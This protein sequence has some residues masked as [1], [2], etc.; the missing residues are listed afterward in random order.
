[1][2]G[3]HY[4]QGNQKLRW[5]P[6]AAAVYAAL[7]GGFASADDNNTLQ[8]IIVTAT[9]RA[10]SA[11]DLPI[12]IS[13]V[14]GAALDAAGI[15]DMSGL[16]RSMAGVN[17]TDKGPFTL[18]GA[19]L[20]IRGLNSDPTAYIFGLG[21]LVVP[22]V[23]TYVD[24][25]P[26]FANLKLE[27]LDRVEVLRGPQ[28]TLYGSGSLGGTIR[29]VQN[30]PDPGAF[31]AKLNVG[32]S[33]T[34]HTHAPNDE[35]SGVL[36]IPLAENLALRLNGS[37]SEQAGFI[38]QPLLY[39]QNAAGVPVPAQPGNLLSAPVTYSESGTNLYNYHTARVALLW[40]PIDTLRLQLSY[41]HQESYAGGYP[42]A[43][44]LY[45][46]QALTS[47]DHLRAIS[48]DKV[49]VI[50]LTAEAQL[51]FATLT[52]DSSWGRHSNSS[53]GDLTDWYENF[54]FYSSLYGSNPRAL[55]VDDEGFNDKILAEEIRLASK[56]GGAIDWVAGAFYKDQTTDITEHA[57]YPGY[58][59]YF[60]ACVPIYG[61]SSGN[62]VTPSQCGIGETAYT[63][64]SVNYVNGIP[65]IKDQAYIGDSQTRFTDMALF[66]ETTWHP[67][68]AL[69]ITG[70][71]RILKQTV[72]QAQQVGLLFDGPAYLT[73]DSLGDS[74]RR[75]L[76]K[77]NISY[78][79][80]PTNLVYA[81]WSQGFRR[82]G[83]NALPPTEP[84]GYT[85]NPA[86]LHA[87]PDKADNYEVGVKG[88]VARRLRYSA[89]VY[90]IQW[91]QVQEA[92]VLTP[93][94]LP[95]AV[96]IGNA[97]SRGFES[98]LYALLT[99]KL[100]AQLD[101][102]Y[103]TTK[104]TSINQEI[105]AGLA[106]PAPSVGAPLPGTPKNSVALAVEYT[107][108]KVFGGDLRYA[109]S[110]H[111]QSSLVP[112]LSATIPTVAGFA[113][114]DL[115]LSYLISHLTTTLYVDNVGNQLGIT[116]YTDPASLG[117]NYQA[118]V[119]RPR[120]VGVRIAYSLK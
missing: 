65:I 41:H 42:Y 12:S 109:V 27:D 90:D 21:S 89:A 53:A 102:T 80:D 31:D 34:S 48:N 118:I 84:G 66:G 18:N 24:D 16:A 15:N 26:L 4:T 70:G 119:S 20:I 30:A 83:V 87:Q 104:L 13:A 9:R 8:E 85:T 106:V 86:L 37:Y 114:V 17:F 19:S 2:P 81:T 116:S 6:I 108:P 120:T 107:Q 91:H 95:G 60:N 56:T 100:T 103:D 23:A 96:N 88:T 68:A 79:L 94:G 97:Y 36:N 52:S 93:L 11:Q 67:T 1:M 72:T 74:W 10:T 92:Q 58:L 113:M 69:G 82:G 22:P 73:N 39:R 63:P 47:I 62:G 43:S 55:I 105:A 28:G 76:W 61:V 57:F 64:N 99:E 110:G 50:S 98:E 51:G 32:V 115:R 78:H 33:D 45:G 35:V 25:T 38:N 117:K 7:H 101:Y 44:P 77:V 14:S 49:D 111:Y 40:R 112:A 46:M 75:A 29:F 71:A 54:S 5:G 59:D 3:P